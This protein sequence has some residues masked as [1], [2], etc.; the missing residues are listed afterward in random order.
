M[1]FHFDKDFLIQNNFYDKYVARIDIRDF[2]WLNFGLSNEEK[3]NLFI[4]GA[5]AARNF[6][7]K[8]DWDKYKEERAKLY[9][10]LNISR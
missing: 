8:F 9:E 2:N 1:R 7:L 5:E 3:I 4:K 10:E 6:L